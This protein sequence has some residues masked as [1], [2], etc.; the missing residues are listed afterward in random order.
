MEC[1]TA[2]PPGLFRDPVEKL[3]HHVG[4]WRWHGERTDEGLSH[5]SE[6]ICLVFALLGSHEIESDV[7]A[8]NEGQTPVKAVR[9]A[10]V[11]ILDGIY[12]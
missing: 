8:S 9:H 1:G 5:P 7:P 3:S 10:L 2:R 11:L 6:V 12:E 4:R